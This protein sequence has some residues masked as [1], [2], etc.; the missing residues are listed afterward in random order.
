MA[1]DSRGSRVQHLRQRG[2]VR[3][4]STRIG[5]RWNFGEL[6]G[7]SC[8]VHSGF[9]PKMNFRLLAV[10]RIHNCVRLVIPASV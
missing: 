10:P 6:V 5:E 2:P 3:G 8:G 9:I 7:V 1:L 4:G